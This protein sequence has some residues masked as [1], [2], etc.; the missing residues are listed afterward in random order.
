[1]CQ[2]RYKFYQAGFEKFGHATAT[3]VLNSAQ[4]RPGF[5]SS[6]TRIRAIKLFGELVRTNPAIGFVSIE[7]KRLDAVRMNTS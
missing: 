4:N 6:A 1:M 3:P 2:L 7:P 5:S